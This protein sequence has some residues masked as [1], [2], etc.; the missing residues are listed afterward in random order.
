[1]TRSASTIAIVIRFLLYE[2]FSKS[3]EK[4]S[5]KD[6]HINERK[7]ISLQANNLEFQY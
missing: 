3:T 1:M 6:N 5:Y 4:D 2:F 7:N